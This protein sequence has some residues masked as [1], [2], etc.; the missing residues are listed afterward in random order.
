MRKTYNFYPKTWLKNFWASITWQGVFPDEWIVEYVL[1]N[2]NER[3]IIVHTNLHHRVKTVE[4]SEAGE[5]KW[6]NK[7]LYLSLKRHL[8]KWGVIA[9]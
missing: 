7:G 4:L 6:Y 3:S 8:K 5:N 1:N 2:C 9:R